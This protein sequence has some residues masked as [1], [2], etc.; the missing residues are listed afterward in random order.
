MSMYEESLGAMGL[1]LPDHRPGEQREISSGRAP[2]HR[3][4]FVQLLPRQMMLNVAD[5]K[6]R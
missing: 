1:T 3:L 4:I 2:A 5:C 6:S